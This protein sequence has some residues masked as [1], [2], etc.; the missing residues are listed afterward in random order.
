MELKILAIILLVGLSACG[1]RNKNSGEEMPGK[2]LP[3]LTEAQKIK[4]YAVSKSLNDIQAITHEEKVAQ[5]DQQKPAED[6]SQSLSPVQAKLKKKLQKSVD[7]K[8]CDF[9][10]E[11]EKVS[12]DITLEETA[13]TGE[14]C[15]IDYRN[16]QK[17][18]VQQNI[19]YLL[20]NEIS[21]KFELNP[22]GE[23]ANDFDVVSFDSGIDSS[24][25]VFHDPQT[26]STKISRSSNG[27]VL[28][29]SKLAG[30]VR[31]DFSESDDLY[32]V[33]ETDANKVKSSGNFKST[34]T[35]TYA[36][37]KAV[38]YVEGTFTNNGIEKN[39]TYYIN[40][41]NVSK[42]EFEKTF[43]TSDMQFN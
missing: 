27:Y 40:G 36:D 4:T 35:Q 30:D 28:A 12:N 13:Y 17:S 19:I 23:M 8:K 34:V 22:K 42:E 6:G 39:V 41:E 25:Q 29:K 2:G 14:S 11:Q 21:S 1:K 15:P 10:T 7:K 32:K 37:F 31:V 24:S 38:G 9:L 43:S 16:S 33:S 5:G 3:A 18:S 20:G 26:K